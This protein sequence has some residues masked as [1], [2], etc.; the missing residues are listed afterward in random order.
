MMLSS[1]PPYFSP[2]QLTSRRELI[3]ILRTAIS[4]GS[5]R[6]A[7]HA[8]Y[9]W[10]AYY[11]GDLPVKNLYARALHQAGQSKHALSILEGIVQV[12]A[13]DQEAWKGII[14]LF[15]SAAQ[16]PVPSSQEAFLFADSLAAAARPIL[17]PS[18]CRMR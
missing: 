13:E 11:P 6:F 4:V 18:P 7:R 3:T 2:W 12:D 14:R 16:P 15:Q 1:M 10:L 17:T 8:A 5:L 9:S